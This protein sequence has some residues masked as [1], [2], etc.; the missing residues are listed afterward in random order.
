MRVMGI[1][2]GS[3]FAGYGVVEESGR[4]LACVGYGLIRTDLEAPLDA[5]LLELHQGFSGALAR[6]RP[7][8]VAVEGVFSCRN[9]RSAL[10]L[11]HA[12]G[13]ALLAAA[14]AGLPVFEYPPAK[15]KRSIGAGGSDGK[16][17]V[18]RMVGWLLGVRELERADVSDALAVA[19]C[20]L[21]HGRQRSPEERVRKGAL[22]SFAERLQP[23]YRGAPAAAPRRRGPGEIEGNGA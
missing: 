2:P 19:I 20:H 22:G 11:G 14:Q 7:E 13:V 10:V 5:R 23:S 18:A 17:A 16:D 8:A 15:V 12:R 4:K 3:R 21:N 9:P 1:D 6:F